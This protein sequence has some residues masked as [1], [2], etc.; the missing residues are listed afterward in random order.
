MMIGQ[1][2]L[3]FGERIEVGFVQEKAPRH[4]QIAIACAALISE[5]KILR[6]GV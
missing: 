2:V 5:I 6:Q 4:V 3:V 1:D